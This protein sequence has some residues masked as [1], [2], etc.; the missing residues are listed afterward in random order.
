MLLQQLAGGKGAMMRKQPGVVQTPSALQA[1]QQTRPSDYFKRLSMSGLN[2]RES[3]TG[4]RASQVQAANVAS[5]L[6]NV[7]LQK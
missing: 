6:G 7:D 5:V 4:A 3:M 1:K 2:K